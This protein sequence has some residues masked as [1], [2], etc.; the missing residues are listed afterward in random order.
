MG[1][2]ARARLAVAPF[3]AREGPRLD[4]IPGSGSL[5]ELAHLLADA[6]RFLHERFERHGRVWRTRLAYPVVFVVGEQANK[7]VLVTKRA[8]FSFGRGYAQTAV[9]R[10]FAGSIMLQ[11][12]EAHDRMRDLLTPAVGKLAIH[13]SMAP[14]LGI[15]ESTAERLARGG[16]HDV[17]TLAQRTTFDVA[18]NVLTGLAL[19]RETDEFRPGFEALIGGIMA[20]IKLRIPG[21]RLDR[22]LRARRSLE[23]LLTPRV[24]AAR[25]Q[26]PAGLLGQLAHHRDPSGA[27][28]PV[29]EIVGHLLLLFWAGY[30]TTAS[31][32]SWTLHELAH[33]V[34]W[35]ERLR[36]EVRSV[37]RD[38]PIDDAR[39]LPL[40]TAFLSE[41]ERLYPSALFFPRIALED[42]AVEGHVIPKGTPTFY[43]PYL[44]HRDPATFETPNAFDPERWLP[45]RGERRA[46]PARLVGFGGGP[47]ICLGKS[48]AKAQ[49]RAMVHAI[50][51]RGRVEPDPTCRPSVLALPVHHPLG[52]KIRIVEETS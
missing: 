46:S 13:E 9:D 1:R 2:L 43:S 26:P 48:F 37:P 19:G 51:R 28:L 30:D 17:Y 21:G 50:L 31:A 6:R 4:E 15:W 35:Q 45:S 40:T 36:G 10:V 47:R 38:A 32:A 27:P 23:R 42:V 29:G 41:I 20:P 49:L 5:L 33:R 39:E 12:G 44:S 7:T 8:E 18:A 25:A 22:A 11:D 24:L 52:S 16:V 34:D 3:T 14:V